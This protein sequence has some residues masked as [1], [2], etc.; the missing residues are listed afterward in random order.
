MTLKEIIE[1]CNELRVAEKRQI[2]DE[3]GELVFYSEDEEKW[4]EILSDILGSAIKP[5]GIKPTK[6]DINLTN[7]Y[8]GIRKNQTL[9]RREDDKSIVIAMFWPWG[10]GDHTTLKIIFADLI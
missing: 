8:G 3:Y 5:A 2:T 7:A 4:S 10:D 1:R 9:F 6:Y